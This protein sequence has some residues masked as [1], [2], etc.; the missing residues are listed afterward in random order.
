MTSPISCIIDV[1]VSYIDLIVSAVISYIPA[2]LY[3]RMCICPFI[4]FVGCLEKLLAVLSSD[5][6]NTKDVSF[7]A[8]ISDYLDL[9]LK[10]S[11]HISHFVQEFLRS[12]V[13]CVVFDLLAYT[14]YVRSFAFPTLSFDFMVYSHNLIFNKS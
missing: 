2:A 13:C 5:Y 12:I 4:F 8:F 10:I 6:N 11:R 14:I 1:L 7:I 3:F 9:G